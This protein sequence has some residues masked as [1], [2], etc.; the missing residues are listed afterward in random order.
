M[1]LYELYALINRSG[2]KI[3]GMKVDEHYLFTGE[4]WDE[5]ILN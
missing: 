1:G 3:I 5:E 4:H 2:G